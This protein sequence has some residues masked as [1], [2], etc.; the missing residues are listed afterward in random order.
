MMI[1][2]L[3]GKVIVIGIVDGIEHHYGDFDTS[4]EA[5][6]FIQ[7]LMNPD[8][9]EPVSRIPTRIWWEYADITQS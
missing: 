9:G 1:N 8:N 6:K 5:E 3:N 7:W 4:T 2:M